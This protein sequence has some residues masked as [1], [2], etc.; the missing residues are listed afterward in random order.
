LA[1]PA[2]A[3]NGPSLLQTLGASYYP[4]SGEFTTG[5]KL[6]LVPTTMHSMEPSVVDF[7]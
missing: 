2:P 6:D 5:Q 3:R 4:Y 7:G 1:S